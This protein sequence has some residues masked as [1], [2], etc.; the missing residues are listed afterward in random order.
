MDNKITR[1]DVE[2]NPNIRVQVAEGN[3]VLWS[4]PTLKKHMDSMWSEVEK[5]DDL[6]N[7]CGEPT[8]HLSNILNKVHIELLTAKQFII[9]QI[10]EIYSTVDG[11]KAF[12]ACTNFGTGRQQ[13]P[14]R[15]YAARN[16]GTHKPAHV[17]VL[18]DGSVLKDFDTEDEQDVCHSTELATDPKATEVWVEDIVQPDDCDECGI[19]PERHD[20]MHSVTLCDNYVKEYAE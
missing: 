3:D 20:Q 4:L 13:C 17:V 19:D 15:Y 2:N 11:A 6:I 5:I 12:I 8:I 10:D 9:Q 16:Y 7:T 18:R 1:Q 14:C